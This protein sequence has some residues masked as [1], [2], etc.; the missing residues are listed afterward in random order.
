MLEDEIKIAIEKNLSAEVGKTLKVVLEKAE[1][2]A[3]QVGQL[4]KQVEALKNTLLE[5]QAELRKHEQ[6]DLRMKSV[7]DA[8]KK[9][10]QDALKIKTDTLEYQLETEKDKTKFVTGVAMGLVRNTEFRRSLFDNAVDFNAA[11]D[12]YG[13]HIPITRTQNSTETNTTE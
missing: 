2:D 1:K 8:E 9:N 10:T 7:E 13:N 5:S 3:E 12:Q 6:L 4:S 11:V